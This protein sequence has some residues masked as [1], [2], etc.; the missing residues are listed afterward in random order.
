MHLFNQVIQVNLTGTMNVI[1][2]AAEQMVKNSP[3]VDG[4]RGVVINTSSGAAFEGQIGQAAHSASKSALVGMTLPLAREFAD[5][6]IRV[7]TIAPELF[8]TPLVRWKTKPATEINISGV[9][10]IDPPPQL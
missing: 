1:R 5:Y 3:N 8:G 2:S 7:I 6:G 9:E 10:K 4:E